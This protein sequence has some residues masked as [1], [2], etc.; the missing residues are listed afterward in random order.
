M[1]VAAFKTL[2]VLAN[3][4]LLSFLVVLMVDHYFSNYDLLS[5]SFSFHLLTFIWLAIRGT[6]WLFTVVPCGEWSPWAFYGLYW[7]A[8]P[9]EFG[10]FM[11]LPLFF[12]QVLYP[13]A[14]QRYWGLIRYIYMG[15]IVGLVVFQ[16]SWVFL[17]ALEMVR[18]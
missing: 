12:T 9:V 14:W 3:F 13:A 7:M 11:L 2:L 18:S 5:W 15:V 8:N 17:T 10:S 4:S 1:F 16:A 6:F